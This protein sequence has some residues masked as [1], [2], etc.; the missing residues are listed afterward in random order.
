MSTH[1]A[2]RHFITLDQICPSM[3]LASAWEYDHDVWYTYR[4]PGHHL[5][6]IEKGAIEARTP[7]GRFSGKAG[8]L[9]CFRPTE[10]NEY[11]SVGAIRFYQL[12]VNFGAPPRDQ[13]TP[14]LDEIGPLPLHLS[15]GEGFAPMRRVFETCCLE[16]SQSGAAHRLRVQ[17]AVFEL[18][19]IVADAAGRDRSRTPKLDAWQ[20][21]RLRLGSQ[22]NAEMRIA[23]LAREMGIGTDHFIRQFKQRFGTSPKAYR[24]HAKMREAARLLRAG[25]QSVKSIAYALGFPDTKSF[26]RIFKRTLGMVPSDMRSQ[27]GAV[28]LADA[29][30]LAGQLYPINQHVVPPHAGTDWFKKWVPR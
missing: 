19:A 5:L 29:P 25:D 24:T 20:R 18:L 28:G 13:H 14:Y 12:H 4:N 27:T 8:D 15:L 26:S 7:E 23:K 21:M 17:A 3:D 11:G 22:L 1:P 10:V 9:L 2:Q 6:L 16:L 30:L